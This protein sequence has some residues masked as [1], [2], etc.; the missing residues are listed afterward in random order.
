MLSR[1]KTRVAAAGALF[2]TIIAAVGL[3]AAEYLWVGSKSGNWSDS[4]KWSGNNV[5]PAGGGLSA[6]LRFTGAGGDVTASYDLSNSF[7]LNRASLDYFGS[8]TFTI[9]AYSGLPLAFAGTAPALFQ[10]GN[11]GVNITGLALP[12][13][14]ALTIAGAGSGDLVLGGVL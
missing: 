4:T 5:P 9:N 2:T 13:T 6:E 10:N 7:T 8:G 11:G 1:R 14:G 12:D 3:P